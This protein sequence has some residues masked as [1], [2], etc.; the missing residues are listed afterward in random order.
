MRKKIFRLGPGILI[1]AAFIGPGT[2]TVCTIVGVN[3]GMLLLW[4][5]LFSVI[6]TIISQNIAAKISWETKKG[7]AQVLLEYSNTPLKKWSLIIL[8]ISAIFFGN[9][10]YEA[11]NITGAKIGLQQIVESEFFDLTGFDI[12]PLII[13]FL[14]SAI[15]LMGS[16]EFIKKIL[17]VI[18]VLMSF[19]F[20]FAAIMTKPDFLSILNGLF[21]PRFN[22]N[23]LTLL[24]SV[25]GTTIVPYNLFLHSALVKNMSSVTDFKQIRMDT[26][27]SVSIGGLIS[28]CI[29][30]AAANSGLKS[31]ESVSDLGISL[32]PIYGE[33]S[34]YL[35]SIGLFGA[36]LSSAITAP[37][38]ASY[39]VSECFDWKQRENRSKYIFLFVLITGTIF[40]SL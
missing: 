30:L 13:C 4:A 25:I 22:A 2:L 29:V 26:I 18:V 34:E 33:L 7:L 24:L 11:G 21:I 39:V 38:A 40:S 8:L 16:S 17:L 9:S 5:I 12:L 31:V 37:L 28:L 23:Q 19:S 10:A 20:I 27:I 15:Y 6:I 3:S 1:T 35:I 36:G 32:S 14:I